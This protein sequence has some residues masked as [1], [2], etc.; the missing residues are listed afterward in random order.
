MYAKGCASEN[1]SA[2]KEADFALTYFLGR[3]T[4]LLQYKE[5]FSYTVPT[6]KYNRR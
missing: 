3:F 5:I 4:D 1:W 2:L 6:L